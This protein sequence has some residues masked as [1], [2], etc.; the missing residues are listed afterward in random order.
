[1]SLVVGST[2]SW[3][4]VQAPGVTLPLFPFVVSHMFASVASAVLGINQGLIH[5]SPVALAAA[6]A[7]PVAP[8]VIVDLPNIPA[9]NVGVEWLSATVTRRLAVSIDTVTSE[10]GTGVP[11]IV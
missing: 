10:V 3:P 5:R 6:S 2:I 8:I 1:M 11:R 4:S 7:T 9:K